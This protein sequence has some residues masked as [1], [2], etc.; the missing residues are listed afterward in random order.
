[1]RFIQYVMKV[2]SSGQFSYIW[3]SN[4]SSML[5]I[6]NF[7][8]SLML[9]LSYVSYIKSRTSS[10]SIACLR[11]NLAWLVITVIILLSSVGEGRYVIDKI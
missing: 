11:V 1:M 5:F 6:R 9:D 10:L 2:E 4:A 7:F 8:A 3:F